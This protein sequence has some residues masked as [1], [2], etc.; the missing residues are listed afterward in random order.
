MFRVYKDLQRGQFDIA[1]CLR[2][3]ALRPLRF[4]RFASLRSR[5]G[6]R[7]LSPE[8]AAVHAKNKAYL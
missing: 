4:A 2:V 1:M 6:R 8:M 5:H 3:H 7:C